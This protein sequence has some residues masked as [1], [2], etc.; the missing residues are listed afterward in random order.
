MP[1]HMNRLLKTRKIFLTV[2]SLSLGFFFGAS[3]QAS[4]GDFMPED[5]NSLFSEDIDIDRLPTE[6]Y[7]WSRLSPEEQSASLPRVCERVRS[8]HDFLAYCICVSVNRDIFGPN[9]GII[10]DWFHRNAARSNLD[11]RSSG[12][13]MLCKFWKKLNIRE[14]V[15]NFEAFC[16]YFLNDGHNNLEGVDAVA[17]A[18]LRDSSEGL[19]GL[20]EIFENRDS[21]LQGLQLIRNVRARM[22]EQSAH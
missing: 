18:L 4:S 10:V 7:S 6:Y 17:E 8:V 2:L 16:N 1:K 20:S 14:K 21:F 5:F 13:L 19:I 12:A 9:F 3:L 11:N 22:Q 15:D